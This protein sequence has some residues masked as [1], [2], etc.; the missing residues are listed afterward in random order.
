ME[1]VSTSMTIAVMM[2]YLTC[3][4]KIYLVTVIE[5]GVFNENGRVCEYAGDLAGYS[6]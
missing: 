4:D 1:E 2:M 6:G 5:T 3:H